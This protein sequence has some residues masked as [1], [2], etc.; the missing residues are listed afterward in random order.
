MKWKVKTIKETIWFK[1][2]ALSKTCLFFL[3]YQAWYYL[4]G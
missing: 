1:G 4:Q 3:L 2:N